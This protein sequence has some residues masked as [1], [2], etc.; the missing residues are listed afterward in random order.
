MAP[1]VKTRL[2]AIKNRGRLGLQEIAGLLDATPLTVFRWYTGND[3]PEPEHLTRVAALDRLVGHL[4]ELHEPDALRTW[5][6]SPHDGLDNQ[7]PADRVRAGEV[8]TVLALLPPQLE[9]V[10]A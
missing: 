4:A 3:H 6:Y 5:L 2:V 1:T 7:L 10:S 8:A 9:G